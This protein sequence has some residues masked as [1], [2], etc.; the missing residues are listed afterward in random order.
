MQKIKVITFCN[1]VT[2]NRKMSDVVLFK[3]REIM[4]RKVDK[5]DKTY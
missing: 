2:K 4:L 1:K 3:K 5:E